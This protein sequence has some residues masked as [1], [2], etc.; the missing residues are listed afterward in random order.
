MEKEI[1]RSGRSVIRKERRGL[2]GDNGSFEKGEKPNKK[3]RW[4]RKVRFVNR[5]REKT[6][7][8]MEGKLD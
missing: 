4:R 7:R 5:E 2:D 8:K 3:S 1:P 6:K